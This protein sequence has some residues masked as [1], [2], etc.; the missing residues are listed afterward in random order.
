MS[1]EHSGQPKAS[2]GPNQEPIEIPGQGVALE[3]MAGADGFWLQDSAT[4]LMVINSVLTMDRI[5]LDEI[6]GLWQDR[7]VAAGRGSRFPRFT[8]RVEQIGRR[9]HWVDDDRYDISRHIVPAPAHVRTAEDLREYVSGLAET[10]LPA[11]RPLWQIQHVHDFEDGGSAFISRIHHCMGDGLA[12]VPVL[13]SVMDELASDDALPG[14]RVAKKK[15]HPLALAAKLPIMGPL[16]LAQ[17]M[18]WRP[19]RSA[20]HGSDLSGSKRVAWSR[21]IP[22]DLVKEVKGHFGATV[23]DVLMACVAGAF[24]RY[25][26]EEAGEV[27]ARIRVSMPVSVRARGEKPVMNNRF[28]AVL[29]ELPSGL[30]GVRAR[31]A[32]TRRRMASLKR[33]VE[34]LVTYGLQSLLVRALPRGVSNR[35]VDFLA[36]KCTCVVTNVPGPPETLYIGGRKVRSM[37]FWVPQRAKIGIGISIFSFSGSVQVGVITDTNL[38]P[39]PTRFVDAFEA[40]FDHMLEEAGLA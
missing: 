39:D 27:P 14:N 21:K 31:V 17:K 25:L 34:P 19:D 5:G 33:S 22:V 8:R 40:E 26:K 20:V 28:A 38:I 18:L 9:F 16:V 36:N 2:E 15:A 7:V 13:F 30:T 32:E 23:N 4:N 11:D 35:L 6:R 37:V 12:L 29:L 24:R 1:V 10:P 3:P